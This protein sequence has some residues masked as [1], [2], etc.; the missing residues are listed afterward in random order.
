MKSATLTGKVAKN[1]LES[2]VADGKVVV[3][4]GKHKSDTKRY[5]LSD[6]STV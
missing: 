1:A 6:S 3:V 2:L 4:T 5:C